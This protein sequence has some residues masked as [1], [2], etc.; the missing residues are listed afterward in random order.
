MAKIEIN[1]EI[2]GKL[3]KLAR[4]TGM[5]K[6]NIL[7]LLLN[8]DTGQELKGK[9]SS[10]IDSAL[11]NLSSLSDATNKGEDIIG[12]MINLEAIT[13]FKDNKSGDDMGMSEMMKM[14]PKM[15]MMKMIMDMMT[16][17][18]EEKSD[19][20]SDMEKF[21]R[22]NMLFGGGKNK[23]EIHDSIEELK[24]E[25]GNDLD[26]IDARYNDQFSL[27]LDRLNS[28]EEERK[29]AEAEM[30]KAEKEKE[31]KQRIDN[32]ELHFREAIDKIQSVPNNTNPR[33]V[34]ELNSF[35]D[36]FSSIKDLNKEIL[37]EKESPQSELTDK[38]GKL[39]IGKTLEKGFDTINKK[40][41]LDKEIELRKSQ[42]AEESKPENIFS[43]EN[44][45][46]GDSKEENIFPPESITPEFV[47]PT[48]TEDIIPPVGIEDNIVEDNKHIKEIESI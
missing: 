14:I 27:L 20:I 4:S 44:E 19:I 38:E 10:D 7:A 16:P 33:L 34:D 21:E 42:Q 18:K 40:I 2:D 12:K 25:R 48:S 41:E 28:S 24:K 6:N 23:D 8:P 29:K 39:N 31:L 11:H 13:K 35:K 47:E 9:P 3:N 5:D 32:I 22:M 1:E 17:K 30:I 43:G 45:Q 15:Q 36:V 26:K 37:P 46:T